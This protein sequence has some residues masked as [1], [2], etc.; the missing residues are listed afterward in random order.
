MQGQF[1]SFKKLAAPD[2]GIT[3][4]R[5]EMKLIKR[6][7]HEEKQR[8]ERLLDSKLE[9]QSELLKGEFEL[10]AK[11]FVFEE[12]E[13]EQKQLKSLLKK[14]TEE[15]RREKK[16]SDD[17]ISDL[18]EDTQKEFKRIQEEMSGFQDKL[19]EV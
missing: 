17:R 6:S 18:E 13:R 15:L 4:L 3:Q 19:K 1:Q 16:K 5:E 8:L 14:E 11:E 12:M 2:E 7:Q 9:S 10:Q